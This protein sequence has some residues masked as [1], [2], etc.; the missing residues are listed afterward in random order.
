MVSAQ[1]FISYS[2]ADKALADH[3]LDDLVSIGASVWKDDREIKPGDYFSSQIEHAISNSDYFFVVL[4]LN[5]IASRRVQ[6]ELRLAQDLAVDKNKPRIVPVRLDDVKIPLSLYGVQ[7]ANFAIGYK[8]GW[9]DLSKLLPLSDFRGLTLGGAYGT[10]VYLLKSFIARLRE[11]FPDLPIEER[12]DTSAKLI[13]CIASGRIVNNLDAAVVGRVPTGIIKENVECHE[14][15][16]DRSVLTVFTGH[17]LWGVEEISEKEVP[18]VFKDDT[19]FVSRPKGSGL[20]EAAMNYLGPRLGRKNADRLLETFVVYD[21]DTA[22]QYVSEGRGISIMPNI[23][24]SEDVLSGKVWPVKLPGDVSR[25]FY[26]VWAKNRGRSEVAE[27][28]VT[29]LRAGLA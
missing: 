23:I 14:I 22:R 17:P 24:V 9:T 26:G 12:V 7:Y 11:K 28:F 19:V 20:H 10:G 6:W 21:L 15:F 18:S 16:Q 29:L 3:L 5:S 1:I 4:S 2:H 27:E 25:P 13:E 8:T